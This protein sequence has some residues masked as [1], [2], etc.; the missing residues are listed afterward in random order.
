MFFRKAKY[1]APIYIVQN[2]LATRICILTIALLVNF[3][4]LENNFLALNNNYYQNIYYFV[5][6][7]FFAFTA[8]SCIWYLKFNSGIYFLFFQLILDSICVSSIVLLSGGV[9]SSFSF[10]YLLL[11]LSSSL[12]AGF[13]LS[14]FTVIFNFSFYLITIQYSGSI[15]GSL[16]NK[17][18]FLEAGSFLLSMLCLALGVQIL[19]RNLSNS[20]T[21]MINVI[22]DFNSRE[23]VL[24]EELDSAIIITNKDLIITELN[25]KASTL[26]NKVEIGI[27]NI[28]RLLE[29]Y[30]KNFEKKLIFIEKENTKKEYK[31]YSKKV[32]D[33][34]NK[35]IANFF[36]FTEGENSSFSEEDRITKLISTNFRD[37]KDAKELIPGFVANSISMQRIFRLII[38]VAKKDAPVL[39]TGESG[40]GKELVAK[41]IHN[42]SE[43]ASNNFVTVNCGAIPHELLESELFGHKKGSFTGATNDRKGLFEEAGAGTIF[44]DEIGELPLNLQVKLL[45]VLQERKFRAVG[46][47]EEINL[48][49]RIIS[50]TNRNLNNE[51]KNEN[52]RED[53]YYRI[54]VVEIAL[55]PLR[56]RKE[57]LPLLLNTIL[58]K[59]GFNPSEIQISDD[60]LK[61][62]YKY[63]YLGNIR[64]FE[65]IIE[66]A[67]VFE[68]SKLNFDFLD[69][70]QFE[71]KDKHSNM[72]ET[73]ILTLDEDLLPLDLDKLL[74][75]IEQRYLERALEAS[76]GVKIEAAKLLGIN[77]R[78]LRYRLQKYDL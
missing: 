11:V 30:C 56:E 44:L 28:E 39:I 57:D 65:N 31:Y 42:L 36:V 24:L 40:T 43:R 69:N 22:N 71:S 5:L 55:P 49:A 15:F 10:L 29:K 2:L 32:L 41:S 1:K 21:E 54:K 34:K 53:L 77:S 62:L 67:L 26:F 13:K 78:S 64:E 37:T 19:K 72:H 74:N 75:S 18:N 60:Q 48:N 4:P 68:D 12:F 70:D 66:R 52:F 35:F 59:L 63:P 50:A 76:A 73:Q 51:I 3:F 33:D 25:S 6:A 20:N 14:L 46:S 38:G 16:I 58:V 17:I 45:R 7:S 8:M 47:N 9:E 23:K 27:T 61:K